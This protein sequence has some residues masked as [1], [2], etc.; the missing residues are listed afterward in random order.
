M[1]NEV[2]LRE[3]LA[4]ADVLI[5]SDALSAYEIKSDFD[6]LRRF[7]RQRRYYERTCDYMTLV[8]TKPAHLDV[9]PSAWGVLLAEA[10]P[11]CVSFR[12]LRRALQNQLIIP[13]EVLFMLRSSEL[14]TLLRANGFDRLGRY[15]KAELIECIWHSLG[16]RQSRKLAI[17]MLRSR[18]SWSCRQLGIQSESDRIRYALSRPIPDLDVR[19]GRLF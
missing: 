9:V 13:G 8:T 7:E 17:A 3:A 19:S 14:R 12:V 10:Q 16:E 2:P 11:Q 6:T 15:S 1:L 4:I 5:V 18:R